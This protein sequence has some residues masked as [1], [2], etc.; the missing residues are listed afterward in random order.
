QCDIHLLHPDTLGPYG[1]VGLR[2]NEPLPG[3]CAKGCRSHAER[4]RWRQGCAASDEH[5]LPRFKTGRRPPSIN[6]LAS[7]I[8]PTRHLTLWPKTKIPNIGAR[9]GCAGQAPLTTGTLHAPVSLSG[10]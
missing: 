10:T 4:G 6:P 2:P 1:H 5:R 8:A 9:V 7:A 3:S